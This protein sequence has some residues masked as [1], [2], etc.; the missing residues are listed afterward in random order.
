MVPLKTTGIVPERCRSRAETP[1]S[2]AI[3]KREVRSKIEVM[4]A[5]HLGEMGVII[6]L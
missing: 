5:S 3:A 1:L 6:I 2:K 4:D